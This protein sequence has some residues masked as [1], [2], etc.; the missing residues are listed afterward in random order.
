MS[1]WTIAGIDVCDDSKYYVEPQDPEPNWD[2]QIDA[3]GCVDMT[4]G[5]PTGIVNKNRLIYEAR[6]FR[7]WCFDRAASSYQTCKTN[8]AP[9]L[10]L[11]SNDFAA[12]KKYLI[13]KI[14]DETYPTVWT[15]LTVNVQEIMQQ[16]YE[17]PYIVLMLELDVSPCAAVLDGSG[18]P[19][20]NASPGSFVFSTFGFVEPSTATQ[21]GVGGTTLTQSSFTF[22]E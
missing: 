2:K 13:R 9:L 17:I 14:G 5:K 10:A 1:D 21:V 20:A 16:F 18:Y 12:N 8:A 22:A 4:C 3:S 11:Q 19:V 7:I 6:K 15:I